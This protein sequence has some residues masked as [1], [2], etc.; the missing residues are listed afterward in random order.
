MSDELRELFELLKSND[1][2][3]SHA[4]VPSNRILLSGKDRERAIELVNS[5]E[6]ELNA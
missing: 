3:N 5:I 6:K 2:V 4:R 1:D